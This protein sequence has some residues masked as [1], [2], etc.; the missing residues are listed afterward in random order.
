MSTKQEISNYLV[1]ILCVGDNNLNG[2]LSWRHPTRRL[3]A[4]GTCRACGARGTCATCEA[5]GTSGTCGTC[6]GFTKGCGNCTPGAGASAIIAENSRG[7]KPETD[8]SFTAPLTDTKHE[9]SVILL[10][11]NIYSLITP[12]CTRL[13]ALN[14]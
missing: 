10:E 4:C 14:R 13:Y 1:F 8:S 12:S 9:R 5:C 6:G 11:I 3:G 7:S 2:L